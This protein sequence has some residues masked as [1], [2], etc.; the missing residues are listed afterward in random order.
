MEIEAMNCSLLTKPEEEKNCAEEM[1]TYKWIASDWSN[2]RFTKEYDNISQLLFSAQQ[3]VAK[4]T[5][6]EAYTVSTLRGKGQLMIAYVY[7]MSGR[8]Q[9]NSVKT[10]AIQDNG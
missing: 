2:V 6:P 3:I 7:R 8:H 5:K 9:E 10:L 4:E 1:C